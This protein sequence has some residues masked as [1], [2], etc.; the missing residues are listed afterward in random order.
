MSWLYAGGLV[1]AGGAVAATVW[2]VGRGIRDGLRA[3]TEIK[4]AQQELDD[5]IDAAIDLAAAPLSGPESVRALRRLR[6]K[7]R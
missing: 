7:G 4:Q 3:E 1:I 5:A 2:W 6:D